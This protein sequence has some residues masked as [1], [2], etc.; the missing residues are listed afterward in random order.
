MCLDDDMRYA[1]D[2]D[3]IS[4]ITWSGKTQ[5]IRW[6]DHVPLIGLHR[7]NANRWYLVRIRTQWV[8]IL[9]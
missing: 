1:T 8:L 7:Y 4:A 5:Y 6:L 3:F 2:A 9:M